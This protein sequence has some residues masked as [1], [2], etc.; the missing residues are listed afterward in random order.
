VRNFKKQRS[1]PIQS[2]IPDVKRGGPIDGR[3]FSILAR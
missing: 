3:P 2:R 1:E